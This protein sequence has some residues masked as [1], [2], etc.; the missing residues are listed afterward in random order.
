[1]VGGGQGGVGSGG[2][3]GEGGDGNGLFWL[4]MEDED[5]VMVVVVVGM[6]EEMEEKMVE[7]VSGDGGESGR[8]R[9]EA[10]WLWA[11]DSFSVVGWK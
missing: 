11:A 1:M 6:K 5:G 4:E 10:R 9:R 2:D 7:E 8:P 3:G